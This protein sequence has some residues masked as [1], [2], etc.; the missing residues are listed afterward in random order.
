M[1]HPSMN[2][3]PP[4]RLGP[5]CC[6]VSSAHLGTVFLGFSLISIC[7]EISEGNINGTNYSPNSYI[8]LG[9]TLMLLIFLLHGSWWLPLVLE[10]P[11]SSW[12]PWWGDP[13][14]HPWGVWAMVT[15]FSMGHECFSCPFSITVGQEIIKNSSGS[16]RFLAFLPLC[17]NSSTSS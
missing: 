15:M 1:L 13:D 2:Y 7:G 12:P 16:N 9:A 3:S 5:T 4:L 17:N 14:T 6:Y 8:M 11:L 10:P